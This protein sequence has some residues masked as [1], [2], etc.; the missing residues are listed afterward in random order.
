MVPAAEQSSTRPGQYE[1]EATRRCTD[2]D[3]RGSECQS[4]QQG[5]SRRGTDVSPLVNR[6]NTNCTLT[7]DL[8]LP[9]RPRPLCQPVDVSSGKKLDRCQISWARSSS[10]NFKCWSGQLVPKLR[11]WTCSFLFT[12]CRVLC[13]V[14]SNDEA[15]EQFTA[16]LRFR[17]LLE[18]P[19]HRS[20][21][22]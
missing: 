3:S 7:K 14:P 2:A 6:C 12:A 21:H 18:S 11:M 8:H 5:D 13:C 19:S 20:G 1:T 15:C 17:A 10:E 16:P 9:K 4:V 22:P